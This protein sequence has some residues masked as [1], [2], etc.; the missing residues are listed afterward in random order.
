MSQQVA[1]LRW[2]ARKCL[3]QLFTGLRKTMAT[4]FVF[5]LFESM[6]LAYCSPP[7]L[8]LSKD[9]FHLDSVFNLQ[10]DFL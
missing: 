3:A 10:L 8:M 9:D 1:T 4:S 6:M 5:L 2:K 7:I